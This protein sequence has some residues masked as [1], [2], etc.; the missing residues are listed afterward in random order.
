MGAGSSVSLRKARESEEFAE[1]V[2]KDFDENK[3]GVL[4]VVELYDAATNPGDGTATDRTLTP[5]AA[6]PP[7]A[8]TDK[9]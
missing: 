8:A 9:V 3:D 7:P 5:T 1:K 4:S 6:P 2:F